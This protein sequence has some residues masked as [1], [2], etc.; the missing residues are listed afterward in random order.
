MA[1]QR[2]DLRDA[3]RKFEPRLRR[4]FENAISAAASGIDQRALVRLLEQGQIERAINLLRIDQATLWPLHEA[5][6]EAY[7]TGGTIGAGI[8]PRGLSGVFGFDGRH[9]RAE[10]WIQRH[11][12]RLVQ[13][14]TEESAETVRT[15]I[16]AGIEKGRSST[17]VARDIRG[18]RMG[19]R[20]V[21]GSIGLDSPIAES[22]IS[23][24]AKLQSGDPALMR[25]YL[26][27]KLRNQNHDKTIEKAIREGRTLSGPKIEQIIGDHRAKALKHRSEKIAR[28]EARQALAA[29]REEGIQQLLDRPDVETVTKRWQWNL[30]TDPRERH[31]ALNGTVIDHTER[32]DLGNGITAAHPHEDGLPAS[33]TI[34]CN[35]PGN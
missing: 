6:R 26:G 7:V 24:R 32:F 31:R 22:I 9:T 2:T 23:G 33:E 21:G 34:G 1:T 35:T 20:W 5:F 3:L 4:A 11:G 29:G 15:V 27:L 14:I 10:A 25:Q 18:R 13:G 17:A 8:A 19:K 30:S 16:R 28:H 12:A